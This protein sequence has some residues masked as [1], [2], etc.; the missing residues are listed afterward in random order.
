MPTTQA[1]QPTKLSEEETTKQN[2]MRT[3]KITMMVEI[4][5][6]LSNLTCVSLTPWFHDCQ[7]YSGQVVETPN[8]TKV[9][10]SSLAVI[11]D[12]LTDLQTKNSLIK[13]SLYPV[14]DSL[15]A[16]FSPVLVFITLKM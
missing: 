5:V 12:C 4:L 2:Q 1:M 13:F 10:A 14:F 8:I 7:L 6:F 16:R 9:P 11:D 3:L 15:T